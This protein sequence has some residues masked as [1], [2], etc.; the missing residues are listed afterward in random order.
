MRINVHPTG[1]DLTPHTQGFVASRLLSAL[2]P[3]A[4][5]I[6]SV[7][8]QLEASRSRTQ[9]DTVVCGIVVSLHP[10]GVVRSRAEDSRMHVAIDRAVAAIGAEV[11]R[12]IFR[13]WRAAESPPVVRDRQ[14]DLALDDG[15]F[16]HQ[17]RE[18]LEKRE[19]YL[20]PV[21]VRERWRPPG[22]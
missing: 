8:V 4:V 16:S 20:G 3:F 18:T 13:T 1:F 9:P 15:R 14:H 21:L 2:G 17:Q 7:A 5:H 11:E 12:E 6:E 10:S 22:A 19:N